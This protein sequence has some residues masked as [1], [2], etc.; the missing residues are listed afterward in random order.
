GPVD[1]QL[2][3]L[4]ATLPAPGVDGWLLDGFAPA[5]NPDMWRAEILHRVGQLSAPNARLG[6]F[7]AARAVRDGLEAAG[8]AVTRVKGHGRKRHCLQAIHP[9]GGFQPSPESWSAA[10]PPLPPGS[11]VLV[12]GAGVAGLAAAQ[13]LQ[14][15]GLA[16]QLLEAEPKAALGGSGNPAGL[17]MPRLALQPNPG[18]RFL[19]AAYLYGL[20]RL[21]RQTRSGHA[22][23][24]NQDPSVPGG[25]IMPPGS[26]QAAD[27]HR[28]L[29]DTPPLEQRHLQRCTADDAR[30]LLGDLATGEAFQAALDDGSVLYHP[31]AGCL[32]PRAVCA[33]LAEDL[34]VILN[35]AVHRLIQQ[36]GT[37][38]WIALDRDGAPLGSG[39]AVV[40]ASGPLQ[41][42]ITI[43]G[44][45]DAPLLPSLRISRGQLSL[46]APP[47][48]QALRPSCGLAYG[49][50][51]SP[52]F[53][54]ADPIGPL[55]AG[56]HVQILGA[57]YQP[58]SDPLDRDSW[59][60]PRDTSHQWCLDKLRT[61]VPVLADHWQA[62][63]PLAMRTA[64]RAETA[65]RLPLVGPLPLQEGFLDANAALRKDARR[66][67]TGPGPSSGLWV[68]GGM[69]SRGFQ[70][71][72]L[73]AALLADLMT[74]AP[75][76]CPQDQMEA[77]HPARFAIRDLKRNLL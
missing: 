44:Q 25:I 50:Y 53:A 55:A 58:I 32:R 60:E 39:A 5:R 16:P 54:L 26:A 12:I 65:D 73:S 9:S 31:T 10:P 77:V 68:L 20:H 61:M 66:G 43:Q 1:E 23:W 37:G 57:S 71:A 51:V 64:L 62:E 56:H 7:T 30:L 72:H 6:T 41:N 28:A 22:L 15:A 67:A 76:P 36:P 48:D 33:A 4:G 75:L 2:A 27:K 34:P 11:P 40:L 29:L 24:V 8:F 59:S 35:K 21:E 49:P 47:D 14:S 19:Q 3:L 69:G 63:R 46:M 18:E 17:M 42:H 45:Q 38:E 52:A 74:G 13:A 70:T